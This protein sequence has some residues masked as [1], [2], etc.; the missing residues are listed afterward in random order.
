MNKMPPDEHMVVEVDH[1]KR[2]QQEVAKQAED[3]WCLESY[4]PIGWGGQVTH[5]LL[6]ARV[7]RY[8]K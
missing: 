6:F 8:R 5:Y 4:H 2:I 1:H 7:G 3:D